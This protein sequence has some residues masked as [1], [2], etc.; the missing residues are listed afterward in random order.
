MTLKKNNIYAILYISV[1]LLQLYVLSYK[2]SY[3][4]QLFILITIVFYEKFIITKL[5]LK[6][7]TIL[8]LL[9]SLGFVGS[10]INHY[11]LKDIVKD[12]IF[13]T[14]PLIA[15][16]LAYLIA[17]L[18]NDKNYF[19]R[20]IIYL[21]V[22]CAIIHLFIVIFLVEHSSVHSI[23]D[24]TKDNFI[25]LFSLFFLFTY[26]NIF[27]KS[28]TQN[29]K[30]Y[31]LLVALISISCFFYFSRMMMIIAGILT[32]SYFGFTKFNKLNIAILSSIILSIF[33]F[34]ALLHTIN[35][36]R[37]GEGFEAFLYKIKIAP[38]EVYKKKIK[39]EDHKDIWDHWRGYEAQRSFALMKNNP[40]S[41]VIGNGFGSLINLK[42]Y[43][44]LTADKKGIKYISHTHNGYTFI[45]Y[46]LGTIGLLIYFY[47]LFKLYLIGQN[48]NNIIANFIAAI[49]IIYL[50]TSLTITGLYNTSENIIYILGVLI[51][52]YK[53]SKNQQFN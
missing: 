44:P 10:L 13:F 39:V 47:L 29:K 20:L 53:T 22:I 31:I 16:S 2:S 50:L 25:E 35:I 23:R 18:I 1:I 51:F 12:I 8:L 6:V 52:Y 48:K 36:N 46:K 4:L 3:F 43:A 40:S 42:M 28:F 14:K 41:Y 15:L 24:Y 30:I 34:Y 11:E 7:I 26:S 5:F 32:L 45:F 21:G 27:N 19:I 49:A 33:G 17:Y 9:V 37:N 38:Q